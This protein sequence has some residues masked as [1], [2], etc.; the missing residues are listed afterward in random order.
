M[1]KTLLK[2]LGGAIVLGGIA[3][4]FYYLDP[5]RESSLTNQKNEICIK[6][7]T[8]HD[9][10]WIREAFKPKIMELIAQC[11]EAYGAE[12]EDVKIQV[13]ASDS[14]FRP[15]ADDARANKHIEFAKKS[16]ANAL[17]FYNHPEIKSPRMEFKIMKEKRELE[18]IL[19]DEKVVFYVLEDSGDHIKA[20]LLFC[21]KDKIVPGNIEGDL[22]VAGGAARTYNITPQKND[23]TITCNRRPI[24]LTLATERVELFQTPAH[25]V[26]HEILAPYTFKNMSKEIRE[27]NTTVI[28]ELTGIMQKH[29]E[30]EESMATIL[31]RVWLVVYN[32]EAGLGLTD[33][34][35][36]LPNTR[37][38]QKMSALREKLEK[39]GIKNAIEFYINNSEELFGQ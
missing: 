5:V 35:L 17:N 10:A 4:L 23:Y 15:C 28:N 18:Q 22:R 38:M 36:E 1:G 20:N 7:M 33:K 32:K 11:K 9:E 39:I 13:I 8:E 3:G 37:S 21:Y 34:E 12:P 6:G 25:E 24:A 14:Y 26:L 16:I 31:G 2:V 27:K 19:T 30:R 29:V